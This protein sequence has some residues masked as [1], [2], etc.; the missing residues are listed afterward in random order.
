MPVAWIPLVMTLGQVPEIAA[1][2]ILPRLMARFGFRGTLALGI[3]A[4][5]LRFGT[6]AIDPPLWVGVA[7]IALH[8]VA[9][10]GF[11][12]GGQLFLDSEAPADRRASV[13]G[14]YL[15]ITSGIGALVGNV[16]AGELCGLFQGRYGPIF[17]V[18]AV[19]DLA[20]LALFLRFFRPDAVAD[21]A[22]PAPADAQPRPLP[23]GAAG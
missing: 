15:V 11:H 6:L 7:G 9:I 3:G 1:L 5:A 12:I 14:L 8:G 16:M 4:W 20:A 22:R 21:S 13:Q 17:L 18:P 2:A 10:A 23:S 19:I